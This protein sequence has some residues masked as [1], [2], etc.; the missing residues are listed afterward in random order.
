MDESN[1]EEIQVRLRF[2]RSR[3]IHL[4]HIFLS[5]GCRE[6]DP[7][8]IPMQQGRQDA[9]KFSLASCDVSTWLPSAASYHLGM[10]VAEHKGA[11]RRFYV[12][13]GA[14]HSG[15]I[16]GRFGA[17]R[18]FKKDTSLEAHKGITCCGVL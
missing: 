13:G 3:E 15:S 1:F 6:L 11:T 7:R 10:A 14:R 9:E 8:A 5:P 4:F 2:A 16:S 17:L 18:I 12:F